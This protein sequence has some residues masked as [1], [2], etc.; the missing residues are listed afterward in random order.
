MQF[1]LDLQLPSSRQKMPQLAEPCSSHARF[2]IIPQ[3]HRGSGIQ[4]NIYLQ[5]LFQLFK[6]PCLEPS[7]ILAIG[8]FSHSNSFQSY[9]ISHLNLILFQSFK[10]PVW[11]TLVAQNIAGNVVFWMS[12]SECHILNVIFW[13][14]YSCL[15]PINF[16]PILFDFLY[17]FLR[18]PHHLIVY[19]SQW[20]LKPLINSLLII[21]NK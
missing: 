7:L 12:Y 14:S 18:T 3:I 10:I 8:K 17:K 13:M 1:L 20:N 9:S 11:I 21:L 5:S 2:P 6:I 19:L 15:F 4:V 16:I